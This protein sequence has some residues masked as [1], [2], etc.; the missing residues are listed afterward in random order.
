MNYLPIFKYPLT[1]IILDDDQSF[2]KGLGYN[3]NSS[4]F[5]KYETDQTV[6]ENFINSKL[7]KP[8]DYAKIIKY[9][10][11]DTIN[12]KKLSIEITSIV[13]KIKNKNRHNEFIVLVLDYDMPGKNG[14]E[15]AKEFSQSNVYK[16]LLTGVATSDD[17]IDAYNNKIIDH[18]INKS[19]ENLVSLLDQEIKKVQDEYFARYSERI[20]SAIK[21]DQNNICYLYNSDYMHFILDFLK[22]NNIIEYYLFDRIGSLFLVDNLGNKMTIYIADDD[23]FKGVI[24]SVPDNSNPQ[25][26]KELQEKK[27]MLCFSPN[28]EKYE[29]IDYSLFMKKCYKI[30][31]H[32]GLYYSVVKEH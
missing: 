5:I 17:I 16:I 3:L 14:L 21:L 25:V 8:H 1:T 23:I 24:E 22:E 28:T 2:L 30:K 32:S 7:Q 11:P 19:D 12:S 9:E 27:K 13:E 20:I 18:Y 4:N 31:G 15:M 10:Y 26:I 6:V 29:D